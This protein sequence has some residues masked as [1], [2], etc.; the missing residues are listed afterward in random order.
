MFDVKIEEI[1]YYSK[2]SYAGE[3]PIVK[4]EVLIRDTDDFMLPITKRTW[5]FD[6]CSYNKYE[7]VGA[8]DLIIE[9][10]VNNLWNTLHTI[11]PKERSVRID[12]YLPISPDSFERSY[13]NE[14]F[15]KCIGRECFMDK[16]YRML[17]DRDITSMHPGK[18]LLD[19]GIRQFKFVDS[20]FKPL[21]KQ[22]VD[23]MMNNETVKN[24]VK[25]RNGLQISDV[26]FNDPATIV[27]WRDGSRTVVKAKNEPYDP[28]K[29]L[30]MAITKKVYGNK[31]NY[32]DTVQHWL[33][34]YKP[35][36]DKND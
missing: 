7:G 28:E 11:V 9:K 8:I 27:F 6:V 16:Y 4:A 26:I 12:M 14:M 3:Y 29:G 36:E 31:Y 34:R 30:A 32:Y 18:L 1:N 21:T 19:H 33:K 23:D 10:I 5:V 20:R 2:H 25:E 15:A 24:F 13:M 35:K 22:E 17:S